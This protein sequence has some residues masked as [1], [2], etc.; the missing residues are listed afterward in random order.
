V[1]GNWVELLTPP[2]PVQSVNGQTGTVNLTAANVGALDQAAGDVRYPLRTDPDPYPTY[3]TAAEGDT[4]YINASGDA[5]TGVLT[6]PAG[7]AALPSVA[8]TGDL[9]TGVFSPGPDQISLTAGGVV[10]LGARS[11]GPV[12]A[13]A[14]ATTSVAGLA[15]SVPWYDSAGTLLG[16]MP[17]FSA[18]A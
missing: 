4:A 13:L 2:A 7:T 18:R 10:A 8:I 5:M 3:M 9:N 17:L 6:T 15:Q 11:T 16:F 14:V 1:L 12:T